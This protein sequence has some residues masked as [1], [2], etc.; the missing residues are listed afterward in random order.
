MK[1]TSERKDAAYLLVG[2]ALAAVLGLSVWGIVHYRNGNWLTTNYEKALKETEL[3]SSMKTN[4]LASAEAEKSSV[5][6]DTDEDSQAFAE[7]SKKAA[8]A[9]DRAR[10]EMSALLKA[11]NSRPEMNAFE[12][13]NS[14]W[15]KLREVDGEILPLAVQN[16]NLKAMRLSFVPAGEA[17]K[18]MEAALNQLMNASGSLP[19]ALQIT[20]LC[21]VAEVN[22]LNIYLLQAPHIAETADA[23][24]DR[25]EA[26][27]KQY[28]EQVNGA[29]EDL[30]SLVDEGGRALL[31]KAE[32]SY[33]EFRKINAQIIDLSRK[34]SNIRSFAISLGRKRNATAQCLDALSGLEKAVQESITF[35]AT[36]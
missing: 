33:E 5:M 29:L 7:Q 4:L 27:M 8:D 24:M 20:R 35:K 3:V 21:S 31:S 12:Q 28:D 19:V 6:A 17:I 34:N 16:T 15:E 10:R 22:A 1:K 11:G 9:V 18:G 32:A 13:F 14:C 30:R 2:F 26:S 23:E 25:I 36:R